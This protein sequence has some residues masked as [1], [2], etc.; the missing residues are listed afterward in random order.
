MP[1]L[2]G[3]RPLLLTV[4]LAGLVLGLWPFTRV[5]RRLGRAML[6]R[7]QAPWSGTRYF[8]VLAFSSLFAG[9]GL[10]A[11]GLWMA[12]AGLGDVGRKTHVAEIQ[13]IELHPEKLRLYY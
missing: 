1:L 7:Q 13:C 9:V 3:A 12:L 11:L 10:T 2:D 5:L 8:V 4:A 6:R